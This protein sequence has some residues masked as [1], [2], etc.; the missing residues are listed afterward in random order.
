LATYEWVEKNAH[1]MLTDKGPANLERLGH[2]TL[3]IAGHLHSQMRSVTPGSDYH[4]GWCYL[5]PSSRFYA[6]AREFL[7]RPRYWLAGGTFKWNFIVNS[8]DP[9]ESELM[10]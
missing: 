7:S 2:I 1:R 4:A 6:Q 5:L 3:R 8:E 9:R 10:F